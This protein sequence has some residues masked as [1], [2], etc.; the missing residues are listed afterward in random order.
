MNIK[1]ESYK[2]IA[3]WGRELRSFQGYITNEQYNAFLDEA[4]LTAIYK[5]SNGSWVCLEDIQN[6]DVKKRFTRRLA[7]MAARG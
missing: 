2:C 3:M 5:D 6:E 1:P 4:P 7:A